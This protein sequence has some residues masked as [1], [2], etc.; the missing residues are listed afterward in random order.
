MGDKRIP[1]PHAIAAVHQR[2]S[3]RAIEAQLRRESSD[4]LAS[5][6][7]QANRVAHSVRGVARQRAYAVKRECLVRLMTKFGDDCALHVELGRPLLLIAH[8]S[9]VRLHLP[10]RVLPVVDLGGGLGAH[11]GTTSPPTSAATRAVVAAPRG[12]MASR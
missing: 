8:S 10:L 7:A 11:A 1:R 3:F 5:K 6:A 9:G 4:R 2:F 12:R